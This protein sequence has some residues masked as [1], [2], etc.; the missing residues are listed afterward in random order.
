[1]KLVQFVD[2]YK[3]DI[4][5]VLSKYRQVKPLRIRFA[6][7][8]EDGMLFSHFG[9]CRQFAI[10]DIENDNIVTETLETAPPHEPGLLP[11]WLAERGVTDVIA[12][13]IGPK[14]V[15][16]LEAQNIDVVIGVAPK[17]PAEL[18][19]DW[20]NNTLEVGANACTH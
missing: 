7:P 17:S 18:I 12:G 13:G 14:A 9:H 20:L 5:R 8:V 2:E 16:L 1:V 4:I 6:I 11:L 10:L 3:S 15:S 19:A